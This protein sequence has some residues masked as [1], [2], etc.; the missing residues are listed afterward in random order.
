MM[1]IIKLFVLPSCSLALSKKEIV[2]AGKPPAKLGAWKVLMD[3]RRL[4]RQE[5]G[6][7]SCA[8]ALLEY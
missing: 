2:A 5:Q 3:S 7:G 4:W 8:E 6:Y 1:S